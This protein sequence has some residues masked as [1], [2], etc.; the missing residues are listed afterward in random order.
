MDERIASIPVIIPAYEPDEQL[1]I[2]CN[3]ITES[4]FLYI[5]VVND[6]SG[7]KYRKIFDNIRHIPNCTVLEHDVNKGKGR[8]LKTAFKY[9]LYYLQDSIGCLTADSDGQHKI[10]DLIKCGESLVRNPKSLILGCREFDG[11]RIPWK[12]KFGNELTKKVC[13]YLCGIRVS[14]TQTGLRGIPKEFMSELLT[15]PGDRFEFETNM[16]IA[17]KKKYSIVE[18][19]IE[20]IYE[21][22]TNHVTHFDP[23]KDSIR[24]YSIF[25]RIFLTYIF[26]SLSS[27]VIDIALFVLF[28]HLFRDT[29]AYYVALSTVL[30]RMISSSYNYLINYKLVFKS[31]KRVS[32]SAFKYFVLAA[33]IMFLSALFVTLGSIIFSLIPEVVIKTVVDTILFFV[34]FKIQQVWIY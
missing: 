21:S 9:I 17:S 5:I 12:S 10:G 32:V 14:D 1:E 3:N 19:N 18:V 26:S 22:K 29:T 6:G 8:A 16:L 28:C 23:I 7:D 34:S 2:F 27:C 30:A 4:G 33:S 25:G 24:I 20:T 11:E 13:S 15:I 31:N